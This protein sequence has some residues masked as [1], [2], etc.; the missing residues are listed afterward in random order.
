[1]FYVYILYS[2]SLDSFYI[3]Q[4]MDIELRL[5]EHNTNKYVGS[6]TRIAKDWTIYWKN[7]RS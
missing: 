2:Q 5:S 1:M 6:S 7:R 3:G 4:T